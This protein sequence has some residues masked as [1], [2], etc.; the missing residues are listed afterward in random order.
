MEIRRA[1]EP[2]PPPP[3]TGERRGLS[4]AIV[5]K[6]VAPGAGRDDRW[7]HLF[8]Q[9]RLPSLNMTAFISATTSSMVK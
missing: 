2:G 1:A 5:F 6:Q 4:S 9:R 3:E 8:D 7:R